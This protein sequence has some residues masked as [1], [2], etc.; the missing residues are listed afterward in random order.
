MGSYQEDSQSLTL[1]KE[2]LL[3]G[4]TEVWVF[5]E[6]IVKSLCLSKPFNFGK[7]KYFIKSVGHRGLF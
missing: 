5:V 3:S 2:K 7:I 1:I 6:E 4:T